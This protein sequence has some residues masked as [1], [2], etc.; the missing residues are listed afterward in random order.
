MNAGAVGPMVVTVWAC[1]ATGC[2]G[3][4]AP[5]ADAG[6][7]QPRVVSA[8]GYAYNACADGERVG[9]FTVIAKPTQ[10]LSGGIIEGFS[11]VEGEVRDGIIPGQIPEVV[12]TSGSCSLLRGRDLSCIPACV[13]GETC[14]EAGTCIA[15][16]ERHEVGTVDVLGLKDA[17][18]IEPIELVYNFTGTLQ[19]PAFDEGRGV[20]LQAGGGEFTGFALLAEGVGTLDLD[21]ATATLQDGEPVNVQWAAPATPDRSRILVE[22]NISQHGGDPVRIE[23]EAADTGALEIPAELITQLLSYKYS[24]FPSIRLSRQTADSIE[25]PVGCIDFVVAAHGEIAVEIDGLASCSE[26]V[27]CPDGMTCQKDLTCG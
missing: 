9:G 22:L 15:A 10:T 14:G 2:G 17:V 25:L 16:P 6:A 18:T 12:I 4:D 27:P 26:Q 8:A 19:N 20:A 3:D 5:A 24:G 13:S 11:A 1:L 23:C 7:G 21:G